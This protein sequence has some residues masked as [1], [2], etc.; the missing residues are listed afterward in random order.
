MRTLKQ[1]MHEFISALELTKKQR[2][3]ANKQHVYLREQLIKAL[4]LDPGFGTFL[5][6]SYSRKTAIRPFKDIDMFCVLKRQPGQDPNSLSPRAALE[7]IK[8]ALE[9]IYPSKIVRLQNRSV[10]IEFTGTHIGYDI[11]PAFIDS[12]WGGR[13]FRIPDM[14][15]HT[16]IRSDPRQHKELSRKASEVAGQ[17]LKLLTKA[18]KHWNHRQPKFERLQSFHIEVMAWRV[19]N[20]PPSDRIEGLQLLFMGLSKRVRHSTPDPAGLGPAL[21]EHLTYDKRH[22]ISQLLAE[23]A[24]SVGE[25]IRLDR[26][27]QTKAAHGVMFKL[28]GEPY[29]ERGK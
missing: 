11:V 14:G 26:D 28:F 1:A 22:A 15:N 21:D 2:A 10:N 9:S 8:S 27:G 23:C 19:F 5:T 16:W 12:E 4:N 3:D 20:A 25:A 7:L 6:G 17:E 18:I 24:H 29:P 13:V